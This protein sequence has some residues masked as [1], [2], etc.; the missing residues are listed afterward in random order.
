MSTMDKLLHPDSKPD[1]PTVTVPFKQ[2]FLLA[3]GI[4]IVISLI[5]LPL[6]WNRWPINAAVVGG[7]LS[8]PLAISVAWW[9][10]RRQIKKTNPAS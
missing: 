5:T 7:A 9:G 10:Q 1:A 4:A 2:L 6:L 3:L 8:W